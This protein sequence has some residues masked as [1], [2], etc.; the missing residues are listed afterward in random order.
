M[1]YATYLLCTVQGEIMYDH[2]GSRQD[3]VVDLE[4]YRLTGRWNTF[5][6]H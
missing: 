6:V 2:N 1:Y 5:V 3:H 4:Q